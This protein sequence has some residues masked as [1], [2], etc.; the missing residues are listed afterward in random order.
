[1]ISSHRTA[2]VRRDNHELHQVVMQMTMKGSGTMAQTL[3]RSVD[4]T[5]S[6][7]CD[8]GPQ[9]CV[10]DIGLEGNTEYLS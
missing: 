6:R 7:S 10:I 9:I 1:M 5:G 3:L 8:N 4:P 2:P